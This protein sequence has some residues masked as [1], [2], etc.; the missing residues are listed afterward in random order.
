[1]IYP[2]L[3]YGAVWEG[4]N[5]FPPCPAACFSGFFQMPAGKGFFVEG[6]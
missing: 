2:A 4:G 6:K 1:M 5:A 3:F